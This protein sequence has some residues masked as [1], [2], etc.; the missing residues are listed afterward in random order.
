MVRIR[1]DADERIMEVIAPPQK[2]KRHTQEGNLTGRGRTKGSLNKT[3]RLLKDAILEAG[4]LAGADV[5][6]QATQ[7][8][9]REWRKAMKEGRNDVEKLHDAYNAL[10]RYR[11]AGPDGLTEY[12]RWLAH[13]HPK[14]Y[15]A[16]LG[17]VLPY[18]LTAK[19]DHTHK[20]YKS[21]D[22]ILQRLKESGVPIH[23]IMN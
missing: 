3:T 19:V 8:A 9:R 10:R 15:A 1:V 2:D 13:Q 4:K 22:D 6:N 23:S 17:R 18:H 7:A 5:L 20:E 21:R 12:L 14:S 16:L 11:D